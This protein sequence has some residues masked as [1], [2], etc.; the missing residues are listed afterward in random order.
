VPWNR[1]INDFIKTVNIGLVVSA[2]V[3]FEYNFLLPQ[4]SVIPGA[5]DDTGVGTTRETAEIIVIIQAKFIGW[6]TIINSL[7]TQYIWI[8]IKNAIQ[9]GI[10]WTG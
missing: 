6:C 3:I 4:R 7:I 10:S 2:P 5:Y 9:Y 1:T 8:D